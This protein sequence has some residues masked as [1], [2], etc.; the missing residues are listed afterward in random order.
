MVAVCLL[1]FVPFTEIDSAALLRRL[2]N[3]QSSAT[4]S[5][6]AALSDLGGDLGP[7]SAIEMAL[8]RIAEESGGVQLEEFTVN[9]KSVLMIWSINRNKLLK[10]LP[11]SS[12]QGQQ[13]PLRHISTE[14]NSSKGNYQAQGPNM[15]GVDNTSMMMASPSLDMW[16]G[17]PDAHL[18]GMPHLFPGSG[19]PPSLAG[20]GPRAMGLIGLAPLQRPLIGPGNTPG[21]PN[22]AMLKQG[23]E[24]DDLNDLDALLNKKTFKEMQLSKAGEEILELIH[25]PTAKEAAAAAK[26]RIIHL[27]LIPAPCITIDSP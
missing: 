11:E 22:P 14:R 4:P 27:K 6:K 2:V 3:D 21:G 18:A 20:G 19:G 9:G 7:I 16:M 1:E 8:R 10:E 5:E 17:P 13:P 23:T 25:R 12:S 26:A 15:A 24:E